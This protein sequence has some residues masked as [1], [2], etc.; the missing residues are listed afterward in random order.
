MSVEQNIEKLGLQLPNPAKPAGSYKPCVILDN[1]AYI[2]G[3][4]PLLED[5][6]FAQGVVGKDLT[7]ESNSATVN[8]NQLGVVGGIAKSD[9]NN[10]QFTLSGASGNDL[11]L[12]SNNIGVVLVLSF[13][14]QLKLKLKWGIKVEMQ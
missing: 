12:G 9:L 3:Q 14:P 11:I 8:F 2:S 1:M 7:L 5:G 4:G 13:R 6:T 10:M